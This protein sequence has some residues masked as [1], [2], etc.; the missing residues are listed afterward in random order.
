[1]YLLRGI[2]E[3]DETYVGGKPRKRNRRSDGGGS[4]PRGRGTSKT[5]AIGAVERGGKVVARVADNLSGKGVLAFIEQA[6]DPSKS[7]LVTD[8]F[9]AHNAVR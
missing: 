5:P 9:S 8:E 1:M 3:A 4:A 7:M 6:I 2:V